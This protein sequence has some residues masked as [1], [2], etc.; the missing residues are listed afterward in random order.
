M[1]A[2]PSCLAMS[3]KFSGALLKR[4]V[5]V[6]AI[7]LRSDTFASR[8]KISTCTPSVKYAFDLSSRKLAKGRTA[9]DLF[10][11]VAAAPYRGADLDLMR[12]NP[13]ISKPVATTASTTTRA[14]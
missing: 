10:E 12:P 5:E 14:D 2:T 4:W 13:H 9:I 11:T 1:F 8:V 3:G 6:R 7:T